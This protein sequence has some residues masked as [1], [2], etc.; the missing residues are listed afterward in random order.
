MLPN[1]L[2][3]WLEPSL[4]VLLNCRSLSRISAAITEEILNGLSVCAHLYI[5]MGQY[6]V[7]TSES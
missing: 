3:T 2:T 5:F 6:Y 4:I 7:I 1:I